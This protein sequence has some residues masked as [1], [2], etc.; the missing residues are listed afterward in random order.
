MVTILETRNR[1][2]LAP[3]AVVVVVTRALHLSATINQ[4]LHRLVGTD[5]IQLLVVVTTAIVEL[6]TALTAVAKEA[7]VHLVHPVSREVSI[8]DLLTVAQVIKTEDLAGKFIYSNRLMSQIR[9]RS[10]S[11]LIS[12][13]DRQQKASYVSVEFCR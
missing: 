2:T 8:T 9:T 4:A 6:N 11:K 13:S 12:A 5:T 3:A 10:P 7:T 1:E